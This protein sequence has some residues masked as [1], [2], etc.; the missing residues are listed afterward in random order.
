MAIS[1]GAIA[2]VMIHQLSGIIDIDAT[3]SILIL[4]ALLPWI[5]SIIKSVEFASGTKIEF[6]DLERATEQVRGAGL[7]S[8]LPDRAESELYTRL[9][10]EDPT[11]ALASLRIDLERRLRSI[12][13]VVGVD[14][15]QSVGQ[16]VQA[17]GDE[18]SLS[19]PESAV[20]AELIPVLNS[21]IHSHVLGPREAQW[22]LEI[23]PSLIA[24]L[25]A[26]L[27][28]QVGL[29]KLAGRSGG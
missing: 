11:L 26:R 21:A 3:T 9:I 25:E 18:G 19:R 23:G 16:L 17:L 14:I 4:I 24:A 15:D 29:K 7:L 13:E 27:E 6:E 12:G 1:L 28:K 2:L 22:A 20:L 5:R 8:T 10:R